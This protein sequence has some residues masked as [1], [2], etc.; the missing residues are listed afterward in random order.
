MILLRNKDLV[1]H[2]F[3]G[4]E[5][6]ELWYVVFSNPY[7]M[8]HYSQMFQ[9]VQNRPNR[10]SLWRKVHSNGTHFWSVFEHYSFISKSSYLTLHF[11]FLFQTSVTWIQSLQ[12]SWSCDTLHYRY[13]VLLLL[14]LILDSNEILNSLVGISRIQSVAYGRWRENRIWREFS[15]Y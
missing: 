6:P 2:P 10:R 12:S 13:I 11:V 4:I 8:F 14:T 9:M 7:F 3:I 15:P 5:V 1:N